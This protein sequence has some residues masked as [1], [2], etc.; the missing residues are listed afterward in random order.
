MWLLRRGGSE[1]ACRR[2]KWRLRDPNRAGIRQCPGRQTHR[3][4]ALVPVSGSTCASVLACNPAVAVAAFF[5]S[6][7]FVTPSLRHTRSIHTHPYTM[8]RGGQANPY[9]EIVGEHTTSDAPAFE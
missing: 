4:Q 8:F 7:H 5:P 2:P 1:S 9:D 3:L 6:L